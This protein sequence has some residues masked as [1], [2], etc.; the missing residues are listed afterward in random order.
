MADI[1]Q[2]TYPY[3]TDGTTPL[4]ASNLNQIVAKIN[5][6][7]VKVNGGVTPT[8]TVATPT[9]SISGTTATISCSTSGATIYYT[10]NGNTPT[11]SS[12][13]YSSPITLSGACT[14]KAIAV[15]SG[16][17]NS[18]VASQ[19]YNPSATVQPPTIYIRDLAII[20]AAE[21]GASIYYTTDGSTPTANSTQYTNAFT[22]PNNAIVKAI[23][24]KNGSASS[25][26]SASF[27]APQRTDQAP[28]QIVIEDN[29]AT[30]LSNG[31]GSLKYAL[32]DSTTYVDY[33]EP[34]TLTESTKVKCRTT[35]GS[36]SI[37]YGIDYTG[38]ESVVTSV[39]YVKFNDC[40]IKAADSSSTEL[41]ITYDTSSSR[42]L[43]FY[44]C[45]QGRTYKVW[46][47]PGKPSMGWYGYTNSVPSS[48]SADTTIAGKYDT[49]LP[50]PATGDTFDET[51]I[52]E[53]YAY[54]VASAG[55]NDLM[56]QSIREVVKA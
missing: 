29:K 37:T 56:Y 51:V 3:F 21:S 30:I 16:M 39:R 42:A 18:S 32:G 5:E 8:Q 20:M 25:A 24:V 52:T 31:V 10:L 36:T 35:V 48:I 54:M 26:A 53:N 34:I 50:T 27:V 2:L 7:I 19:S 6:L 41:A 44:P 11:T 12:T 4:N 22:L 1:Q 14:I 38:T 43:R 28:A 47:S 40:Y 15:K 46:L 23:A 9:I 33:T 45:A 17:N 49:S 55:S 13:Q